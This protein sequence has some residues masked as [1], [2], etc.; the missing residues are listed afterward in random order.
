MMTQRSDDLGMAKARSPVLIV[1]VG[2]DGLAGLAAMVQ[3]RIQEADQLWGG[4]RL[5]AHWSAHPA[6]KIVIG[7]DIA[8]RVAELRGRGR[9]RVVILASGDPGFYGIAATV[10]SVLPAEEVEIIPHVSALQEAFARAGISWSDAVLTSVH[11]RPLAEV[12]GWARRAPKLG[13]L[14]DPRHTPAV[15]AET[16]LDAGLA[17]CRAI[18]AENLGLPEERIVDTRLSQL[19]DVAFAPLNVLLLI[20]DAGWRPSPAFNPR[21]EAAY[22]HRRGLITKADI[23]ALCLARLALS[24]TDIVWDIGAGSGAVSIEMSELAWRGR[25]YAIERDTDCLAC[26]AE[27]VAAYGAL[28]VEI[29]AGSAPACLADLPRPDAVFVGGTGGDLEGILSM[30]NVSAWPGCRVVMP[31]V[32]VEHLAQALATM[33]GLGWSIDLTQASIAQGMPIAGKT[34]LAPQNPVFILSA[35]VKTTEAARAE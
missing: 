15:I 29:V 34:R 32:L 9:Q 2:A 31:L 19:S 18:V 20:Q 21:P 25:V 4:R 33:R 8:Q 11:A 7:A 3:Q 30:I 23:R 16:L 17:D 35:M 24:E 14:T 12:I 6:E 27:N 28:A 22:A 1:G 10:L 13:L 5:L 26:I